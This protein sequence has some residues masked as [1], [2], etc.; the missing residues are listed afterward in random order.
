MLDSDT[1]GY[2]QK[3]PGSPRK[4]GATVGGVAFKERGRTAIRASSVSALRQQETYLLEYRAGN[5]PLGT[6]VSPEASSS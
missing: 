6:T 3:K 1:R 5:E 2:F 4:Q